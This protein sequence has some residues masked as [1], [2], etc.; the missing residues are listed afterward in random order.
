LPFRFMRPGR[1]RTYSTHP[2][3]DNLVRNAIEAVATGGGLIK[4]QCRC[5][6]R[7][8]EVRIWNNGP[9]INPENMTRIFEPYFTTKGNAGTG[10]G[11]FITKQVIEERGGSITAVSRSGE[12]VMFIVRLPLAKT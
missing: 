6:E 4:I 3:F 7:E 1:G 5:T 8:T 12:G 10:L 2:G 11:L 9:E